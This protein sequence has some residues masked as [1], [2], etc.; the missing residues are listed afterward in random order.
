[1]RPPPGSTLFPYTTLFRSPAV[2][3]LV[4]LAGLASGR[5][6]R[7]IAEEIGDGGG[8]TLKRVVTEAVNEHFAPIRARRAELLADPGYLRQVLAQGNERANAVAEASL[9]EVQTALGMVYS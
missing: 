5:D 6:P 2:S 9:A 7:E 3:N 8:G 4:L 1:M